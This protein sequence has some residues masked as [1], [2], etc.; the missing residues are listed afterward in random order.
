MLAT[1]MFQLLQCTPVPLAPL[2]LVLVPAVPSIAV[3]P[4]ALPLSLQIKMSAGRDSTTLYSTPAMLAPTAR[5]KNQAAVR[6]LLLRSAVTGGARGFT[7]NAH[8]GITN[9]PCMFSA[10]SCH[11]TA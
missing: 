5:E 10:Y 1:Q 4:A 6:K 8:C 3:V 9:Q 2:L 7:T 11:G